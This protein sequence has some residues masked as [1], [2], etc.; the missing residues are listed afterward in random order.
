MTLQ[1]EGKKYIL[2][3]NKL[4]SNGATKSEK[5]GMKWSS[6][7]IKW[8]DGKRGIDELSTAVCAYLATDK[9]TDFLSVVW[10][11]CR[12]GFDRPDK[13]KLFGAL[14]M[15]AERSRER[16]SGESRAKNSR[17]STTEIKRED[18]ESTTEI[19]RDRERSRAA[20]EIKREKFER[21]T[22]QSQ[23]MEKSQKS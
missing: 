4:I 2:K 23:K 12:T 19:V 20:T 18:R 8:S 6:V 15:L 13:C 1:K 11:R 3:K 22:K 10:V 9:S 7:D 21:E 5:R 16:R 17:A 14:R